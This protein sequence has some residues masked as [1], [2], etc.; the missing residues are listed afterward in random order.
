M[1][2]PDDPVARSAPSAQGEFSEW[3]RPHWP[4]MARLARRLSAEWEDALQESLSAA[5]RKRD[6]FDSARGTP[7]NWL[8]A[9]TADQAQKSRRK[10]IPL[11]SATDADV[12]APELD[13][14]VD[15]DLERAVSR[16]SDRQRLAVSLYYFVG[17][18]ITDVA[19]VM[20]CSEGTVKST[21]S[22][23]RSRM[24]LDLGDDYR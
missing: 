19:A 17:L 22:D 12:P 16:L 2:D 6:Q 8:L 9:I 13:T 1:T 5:W 15:L 7:R 10:V 4:S 23:A 24:R 3:V 20:A 11:P 18:P 14:A 21:L